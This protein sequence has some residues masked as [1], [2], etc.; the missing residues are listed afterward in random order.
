VGVDGLEQRVVKVPGVR[1]LRPEEQAVEDMLA[2]W[3]SQQLS[4]A[5]SLGTIEARERLVRRFLAHSCEPPWRWT[6]AHVD[7]FFG[8]LRAEHHA[9]PTTLRSHQTTLRLFC[10]YVTDPGYGWAAACLESPAIPSPK[11]RL[12]RVRGSS[13]PG[14]TATTEAH[15]PAS[16]PIAARPVIDAAGS[17]FPNVTSADSLKA[18]SA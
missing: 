14:V 17:N 3:R 9:K 12:T 13:V 8:D 16:S 15:G 5:L 6:P 18:A 11:P 10:E 7:E 4:R 2:G 1:A